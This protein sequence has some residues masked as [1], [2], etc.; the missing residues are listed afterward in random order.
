[1]VEVSQ[2]FQQLK[3]QSLCYD[4]LFHCIFLFAF[5]GYFKQTVI[6]IIY[7]FMSYSMVDKCAGHVAI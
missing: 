1:M 3:F 4:L 2:V 7:L 6:L 5:L